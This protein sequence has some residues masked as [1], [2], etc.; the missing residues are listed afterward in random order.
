MGDILH[1]CRQSVYKLIS[2][3]RLEGFMTDT[4]RYLVPQRAIDNYIDSCYNNMASGYPDSK[5]GS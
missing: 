2:N 5:G 4:G 3:E 1:M